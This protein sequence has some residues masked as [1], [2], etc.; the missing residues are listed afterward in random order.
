MQYM[1]LAVAFLSFSVVTGCGDSPTGSG[2]QVEVHQV[3]GSLTFS[4]A[5]LADATISFFPL[6]NGTPT[7]MGRSD[8]TGN[9]TLTT[10]NAEDGAAAGDYV[11][12]ISKFVAPASSADGTDPG[13]SDDP[14]ADS[15]DNSHAAGG[16]KKSGS[17]GGSLIPDRYGAKE[18]SPLKATVEAGA[19]NKFDFVLQ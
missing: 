13:H 14:Y 17:S 2:K 4:G 9:Y 3:S 10:Y 18:A 19:E 16:S 7:A 1:R 11:V 5:P 6:Q 15:N 12:L 8:S